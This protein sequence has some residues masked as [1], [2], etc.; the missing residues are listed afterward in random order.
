V[1]GAAT[2]R[3]TL[4]A[5]VANGFVACVVNAGGAGGRPAVIVRYTNNSNYLYVSCTPGSAISIRKVVAGVESQVAAGSLVIPNAADVAIS[6]SMRGDA[7]LLYAN[8][9]LE[10]NTSDSHNNT[11]T[12]VG[13]LI[14]A[15]SPT[16]VER[17][18]IFRVFQ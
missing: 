14:A 4:D 10:V 1:A 11:A 9:V 7:L 18:D 17:F 6:L 15:A 3:A 16:G 2:A 5:G 8:G 12:R 13:L